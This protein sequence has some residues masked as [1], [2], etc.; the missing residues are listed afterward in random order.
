MRDPDAVLA[1]PWAIHLDKWR[2]G[3]ANADLL[4][5]PGATVQAYRVHPL[6]GRV[7]RDFRMNLGRATPVRLKRP[8]AYA[9]ARLPHFFFRLF[10]AGVGSDEGRD[11]AAR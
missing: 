8:N 4:A 5:V 11:M 1:V 7:A 6:P 10:F 2:G 3:V 9:E